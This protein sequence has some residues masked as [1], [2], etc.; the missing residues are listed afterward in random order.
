MIA[1]KI[2][3]AKKKFSLKLVHLLTPGDDD[4]Y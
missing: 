1:L 3:V 2:V 4:F